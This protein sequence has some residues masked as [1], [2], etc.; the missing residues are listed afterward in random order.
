[1]VIRH[2]TQAGWSA[3]PWPV[4]VGGRPQEYPSLYRLTWPERVRMLAL[5]VHRTER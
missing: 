1:M 5:A 3:D 2:D 4:A